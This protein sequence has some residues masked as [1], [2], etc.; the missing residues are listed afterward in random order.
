[1]QPCKIPT[2]IWFCGGAGGVTKG[3]LKVGCFDVR[4]VVESDAHAAASHRQMYPGIPVLEYELGGCIDTFLHH[5]SRYVPPRLWANTCIQASPPCKKL[6]RN[7]TVHNVDDAMHLTRWS[8]TVCERMN[9]RYFWLE[10]VPTVLRYLDRPDLYSEVHDLSSFVPQQRMRALIANFPYD[11][12]AVSPTP[13]PI[14]AMAVLPHLPEGSCIINRYGFSRVITEPSPTIVGQR[15]KVSIPDSGRRT[16][17]VDESLVL[18]GFPFN[19]DVSHGSKRRAYQ[20]I[21]DAVPPPF[22]YAVGR[23]LMRHHVSHHCVSSVHFSP[24]SSPA[25]EPVPRALAPCAPTRYFSS[26]SEHCY[27]DL[28]EALRSCIGVESAALRCVP[29]CRSCDVSL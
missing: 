18:Q 25:Y 2:S 24:R 22:A 14:P 8:I 26:T 7:V 20:W 1:M 17:S 6:S 29:G 12:H 4:V 21:G 3:L 13:P 11:Q 10:N 19:T 15:M 9:V 23:A 28:C 5:F 16:M 27:S